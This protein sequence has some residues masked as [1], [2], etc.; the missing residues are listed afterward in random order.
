MEMSMKVAGGY[1]LSRD[2][3]RLIPL[4]MVIVETEGGASGAVA[5]AHG[6]SREVDFASQTPAGYV[7]IG[8]MNSTLEDVRVNNSQDLQSEKSTGSKIR[9]W[10]ISATTDIIVTGVNEENDPCFTARA[11]LICVR[12][13]W[14]GLNT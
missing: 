4:R 2:W 14:D 10:N 6:E 11:T 5:I 7:C 13:D 12:D 9:F 3:I 8:Y 1:D